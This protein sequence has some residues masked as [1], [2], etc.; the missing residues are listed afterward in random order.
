MPPDDPELRRILDRIPAAVVVI[1]IDDRASGVNARV[2]RLLGYSPAE[3]VGAPIDTFVPERFR[4]DVEQRLDECRAARVANHLQMAARRQDGTQIPVGLTIMPLGQAP[5]SGLALLFWDDSQLE[6]TLQVLGDS[7]R[8]LQETDRAHVELLARL[9]C[10]QEEERERI[11]ADLSDEPI[12]AITVASFRLHQLRRRLSDPGDRR[13]LNRLEEI[14]QVAVGR[15]H[16]VVFD[17]R[18]PGF[19]QGG[20][21][22]AV[23]RCLQQLHADTGAL[24]RLDDD[25]GADLPIETLL[26][27]YRLAQEALTNVRRHAQASTVHVQLRD[28]SDGVLVTVIDDGVGYDP[29]IAGSNAGHLGLTLMHERAQIAG[30]WCRTEGT[31]GAGATVEFWIPRIDQAADRPE[32]HTRL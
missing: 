11:A 6:R 9:L 28:V 25:L 22:S 2:E 4:A 12:L 21:L 32:E 20:F 29:G 7:V 24:V 19:E 8:R 17:L 5:D 10:A 27:A 26:V 3:V 1:G 16:H 13:L 18:P 30:G 23:Q 15:L 14:M 31:P